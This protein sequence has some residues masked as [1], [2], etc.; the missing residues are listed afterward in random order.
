MSG[1][2]L[3]F[4]RRGG[5]AHPTAGSNYIKFKDEAVFNILMSKGVSSDGVG[6]TKDDAAKVTNIG[7]WFSNSTIASF[8]EFQYFINVKEVV[9]GAF[10]NCANLKNILLPDSITTIRSVAFRGTSLEVLVFPHK[11]TTVE[12]FILYD[13]HTSPTLIS[14]NTTPPTMDNDVFRNATLSEVY[15]P[16]EAVDTYKAARIWSRYATITKPLSE[17]QGKL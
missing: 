14:M 16:D 12:W 2:G 8:D 13:C 6:I 1:L 3:T 7:T 10:D 9:K 5:Q 17:Y 11:V 4:L 15:V